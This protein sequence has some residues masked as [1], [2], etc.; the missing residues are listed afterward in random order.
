MAR[1]SAKNMPMLKVIPLGGLGEVGK[2]MTV[3]EYED[4][5][6]IVDCGMSFPDDEMFGIDAVIPDFNYVLDQNKTVR[7]VVITHG[8]EDHI[9]ALPFLLDKID[10]PVYGTK[11]SLGL[12]QRKL[13]EKMMD[14][15]RLMR[16][17]TIGEVIKLGRFEVEFIR[18]NHSI[19][20]S[21]SLFIKCAGLKIVHTGDFKID[22][23]PV[24]G[25]VIDLQRL[26]EIGGGIDLLLSDSTN[27]EYPGNTP[28]EK[29][30]GNTLMELFRGCKSR[31]IVTSFA[32]NIHRTQQIFQAAS[33]NNR[34]LAL[35]GRSMLNI[36]KVAQEL[37]YLK[38][39]EDVLIDIKDVKKYKDNKVVILTTGSQ[40]EPMSALTRMAAGEHR[41]IQIKSGDVVIM[42]AN[43]IPG[44]EKMIIDVVNKLFALGAQVLYSKN[45]ENVHASGHASQEELKLIFSLLKPKYFV[46]VH[47]EVK[48]LI[49]HAE[50]AKEMGV[51]ASNVFLMQN[52]DVLEIN[53]REAKC[54]NAINAGITL[55]DGL[56]VGDIGN[57]VL[58]ERKAL[59][60]FGILMIA[61]AMDKNRLVSGPDIISRG[62]VYMRESSDLINKTAQIAK[63][64]ILQCEKDGIKDWVDIKTKLKNQVGDYLYEQTGRNPIILPIIMSATPAAGQQSAGA[65]RAT[66]KGETRNVRVRQSQ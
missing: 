48:M 37:G 54:E 19:A 46:P 8:H 63:G 51:R 13:D 40:G 47:G 5:I 17:V 35:S 9:G 29:K 49:K 65:G 24:D 15:A 43:P 11:L 36:V 12:I 30:V 66:N 34:K 14:K 21:C 3:L 31:I 39:P 18:N 16:Q 26:A 25:E 59:S 6:L 1:V 4:E 42:S 7:A 52:G 33:A 56:G 60:Q 50:I 62:F 58:K 53:K 2:N 28:S 61:V 23:T 22:Y 44:N 32:S 55:V 45:T 10:V 41:Q 64:V 20:D 57:I 27:A 38:I